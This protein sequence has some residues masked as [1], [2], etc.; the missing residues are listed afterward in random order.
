MHNSFGNIV[1]FKLFDKPI[2]FGTFIAFTAGEEG[3][4]FDSRR[5]EF[6]SGVYVLVH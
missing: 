1:C 3:S 2:L 4:M 6:L 5:D